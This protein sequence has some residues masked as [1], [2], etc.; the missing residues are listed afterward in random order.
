MAVAVDADHFH[1]FKKRGDLRDHGF[2]QSSERLC[3]IRR[4]KAAVEKIVDVALGRF[5]RR[6]GEPLFWQMSGAHQVG[7]AQEAA[8]PEKQ[9]LPPGAMALP[10]QEE[11]AALPPAGEGSPDAEGGLDKLLESEPDGVEPLTELQPIEE[12]DL[13]PEE[14]DKNWTISS[15]ASDQLWSRVW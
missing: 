10:E 6:Q 2:C 5:V 12:E 4:D 9:Q 14:R 3:E 13:P 8:Q 15:T 11:P 7:A 1:P